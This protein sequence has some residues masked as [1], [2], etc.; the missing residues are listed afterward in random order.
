MD[1]FAVISDIHGNTWALEAVLEDIYRRGA[2]TVFNLGDSFYGPLDPGGTAALLQGFPFH[3]VSGNEDRILLTGASDTVSFVM[4]ELDRSSVKWLRS[5]PFSISI[6]DVQAFHG[7]PDHDGEYLLWE[8]T[9][10][11]AVARKPALVNRILAG[12]GPP[13]VLC[14]HDHRP[15]Q[16]FLVCGRT[17]VNPGS[18]GLP[19]YTDDS[20]CRHFME[21]GSPHARYSEVERT[22]NGYRIFTHKV[23]Y[24]WESAARVASFHK[25]EDWAFW[26]RTGTVSRKS[27]GG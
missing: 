2:G 3:T 4:S 5:L 14:G 1:R 25:R 21:N 17:V 24:D 9:G 6:G 15:A 12:D 7:S 18:V 23:E 8:V 27:A 19:A 22:D 13:L 26:L 16:L 11:G 10:E 20:P